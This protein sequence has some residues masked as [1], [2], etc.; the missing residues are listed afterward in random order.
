MPTLQCALRIAAFAAVRPKPKTFG[1]VQGISPLVELVVNVSVASAGSDR[2][3]R[4]PRRRRVR[5]DDARRTP[6]AGGWAERDSGNG[7]TGRD[8]LGH[9]NADSQRVEDSGPARAHSD[10]ERH[11][12]ACGRHRRERVRERSRDRTHT[13]RVAYRQRPTGRSERSR[14]RRTPAVGHRGNCSRHEGRNKDLPHCSDRLRVAR[15]GLPP[16]R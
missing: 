4:R 14:R 6:V 3:G 1:T 12:S 13:R 5:R 8:I 16:F 10:V 2:D 7:V 15:S 11:G 9:G